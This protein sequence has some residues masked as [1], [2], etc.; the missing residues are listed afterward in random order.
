MLVIFEATVV[1]RRLKSLEFLRE[2]RMQPYKINVHRGGSWTPVLTSHLV[3]GDIV[4]LVRPKNE[5]H[6]IPA[7]IVLLTGGVV[8]MESM[9]TG[10][11]TPVHKESLESSCDKLNGVALDINKEHKRNVL[12]GGT[13]ILMHTPPST[14]DSVPS[15]VTLKNPPDGGCVGMVLRT[16]FNTAQGRLV[17]TILFSSESVSINNTESLLFIG[18]LLIFAIAAAAYVCMKGLEDESRSRYKL[19][20]NAIMIVT[21]VVPPE[22]PME[23]SLAVNTSLLTLMRC[24]IFCTE[25]FRIPLAGAVDICC[26]DKTGTLTA[27][28]FIVKGVAGIKAE[29]TSSSSSS[30]SASSSSNVTVAAPAASSAAPSDLISTADAL[31]LFVK[32]VIAGC[33][34][35]TFLPDAASS[36]SST[37]AAAAAGLNS[38]DHLIGDPLEK[39]SLAFVNWGCRGETSSNRAPGRRERLRCLHKYPFSSELKRMAVVVALEHEAGAPLRV[40]CKGAAEVLQGMF[41]PSTVPADYT[42]VHTRYSQQGC[43]VLAL[44]YKELPL[45]DCTDDRRKLKSLSRAD[46]IECG[47]TFAGFLVLQ[48]PLK[49]DSRDVIAQLKASTHQIA[50]ITGDHVLTACSV[51]ADLAITTKPTLILQLDQ[52]T[53]GAEKQLLWRLNAMDD[54]TQT[55]AFASDYSAES[56]DRLCDSYDLGMSGDALDFLLHRVQEES[57]RST[58]SVTA[59]ASFVAQ[60]MA[61]LVRHVAV[62]ARTSPDQKELVLHWLKTAGL[63]TLMCGDGTNDVGSEQ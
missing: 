45:R 17:R 44:G 23:L 52:E 12:F 24:H 48:C 32:Y 36:A 13:K 43:R 51:A 63:T 4:S 5:Q 15:S 28:E 19:M 10:E 47:L 38:L 42:A 9:L 34:S 46:D 2:M 27:D 31:P 26:F 30:S 40:V 58:Q 50:M 18:V 1:K 62:F 16:G 11:S 53:S 7:D 8:C 6:V 60:R 56:L 35:L 29:P 3:P 25:P 59:A 22:L 39:S 33:H 20:L 55:L 49:K 21:S 37:P 41:D 57:K 61:L 14:T 54:S